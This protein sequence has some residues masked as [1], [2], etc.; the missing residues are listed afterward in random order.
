MLGGLFG[1]ISFV[2]PLKAH[3]PHPLKEHHPTQ[4]K[5]TNHP[6]HVGLAELMIDGSRLELSVR[7]FTDDLETMLRQVNRKNVDL[8]L[9]DSNIN[10]GLLQTVLREEILLHADSRLIGLNFIGSE[11]E[12]DSIWLY[13][14]KDLGESDFK[15][16]TFELTLLTRLF[17]EQRYVV[18]INQNGRKTNQLLAGPDF[19]IRWTASDF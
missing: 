18:S 7:V 4:P 15:E 12:D 8:T 9:G 3:H 6:F 14:E 5:Y 2:Y 1:V 10:V 19:R 13:L 11:R 16:W 17:P